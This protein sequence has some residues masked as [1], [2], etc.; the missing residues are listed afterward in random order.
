MSHSLAFPMSKG[1]IS[2]DMLVPKKLFFFQ[3]KNAI[4]SVSKQIKYHRVSLQTK[5]YIESNS[6]RNTF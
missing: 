4:L 2:K 3:Q 6:R 1:T 5:R